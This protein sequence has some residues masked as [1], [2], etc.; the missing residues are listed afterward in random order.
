[1]LECAGF[2]NNIFVE[3][4]PKQK[5]EYNEYVEKISP[6]SRKGW[7]LFRAFL[8]GGLIC[9]IGQAFALLFGWIFPS[10]DK[11]TIGALVSCALILIASILTGFGVFDKIGNFAGGGSI[12]P[13]TGFSNSL[14]SAAM[15]FRKEGIIFGTCANMFR[16]AGPVVVVGAAI[17]ILVGLG[18]FLGGLVNLW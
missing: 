4:T 13:I 17:S 1:M 14:T 6:T 5:K 2:V 9:A 3:F 7:S 18:Y 12:V 11:E 16:I 8:I 15:E 10:Y